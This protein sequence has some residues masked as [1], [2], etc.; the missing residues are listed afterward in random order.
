MNNGF[1]RAI[2]A[3]PTV[4]PCDVE[5]NTAEIISMLNNPAFSEADMV[6]FPELSL[7]GY[8]CGD[9]FH[10]STLLD[11]VGP[12]IERVAN[13][14]SRT[15]CPLVIIGAPIIY[16]GILYNCAVALGNGRV[17]AVIPKT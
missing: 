14:T 7:T 4:Q 6:V 10:N 12:A 13:A 3:V 17:L 16:D 5:A 8:T 15:D 2:A 11:A 9:I 1:F